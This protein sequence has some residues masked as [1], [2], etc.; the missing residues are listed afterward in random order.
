M[1]KNKTKNGNFTETEHALACTNRRFLE[2]MYV[3][4]MFFPIAPKETVNKHEYYGTGVPHHRIEAY[5]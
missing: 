2:K 3:F 5:Q 4:L 1:I